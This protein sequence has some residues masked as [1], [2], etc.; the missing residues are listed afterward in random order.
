MSKIIF[1]SSHRRQLANVKYLNVVR[2]SASSAKQEV[3]H[4]ISEITK[5]RR[6]SRELKCTN[7]DHHENVHH[8]EHAIILHLGVNHIKGKQKMP[9]IK[10][11][12]NAYNEANFRIP[13]EDGYQPNKEVIVDD[14]DQVGDDVKLRLSTD[15]NVKRIK[16][17][18]MKKIQIQLKE[19]ECKE[20]RDQTNTNTNTNN[21]GKSEKFLGEHH[22]SHPFEYEV[23]LSGDAGRFVCNYIYYQ[24]LNHI[25]KFHAKMKL[26]LESQLE[27]DAESG[28]GGE[29]GDRNSVHVCVHADGDTDGDGLEVHA[30]FVHVPSFKAIPEDV[31]VEFILE[32]LDSIADAVIARDKKKKKSKR[33]KIK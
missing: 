5:K 27:L 16:D 11:E 24:S 29:D 9:T 26:E 6:S 23:S 19:L 20:Q 12:Q 21:N 10:I 13:D 33:K 3:D 17:D 30:L 22:H 25:S 32:L 1:F 15:L 31:Q 18:L 28:N 7:R 8:R 14:D 2:V 4:I